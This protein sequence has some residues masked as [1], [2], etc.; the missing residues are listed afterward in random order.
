[1]HRF[2]LMSC[3][4]AV[5]GIVEDSLSISNLN[6]LSINH[7]CTLD[8]RV[9]ESHSHIVMRLSDTIKSNIRR[10]D[11][12]ISS[13]VDHTDMKLQVILPWIQEYIGYRNDLLPPDD[14]LISVAHEFIYWGGGLPIISYFGQS[15][16]I[17]SYMKNILISYRVF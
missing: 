16:D 13:V 2:D 11:I 5:A 12:K 8:I 6:Y 9:P 3:D 7:T 14:I 15:T 10:S 4:D 1:M 17:C